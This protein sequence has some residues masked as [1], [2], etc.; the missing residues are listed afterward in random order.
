MATA[1]NHTH[2]EL[3]FDRL[4]MVVQFLQTNVFHDQPEVCA[5]ALAS[6]T[7]STIARSSAGSRECRC[8]VAES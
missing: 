1:T 4:L 3:V 5:F 8:S 2:V 7:S 6:R